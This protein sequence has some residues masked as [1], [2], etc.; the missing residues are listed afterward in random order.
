M[1]HRTHQKMRKGEIQLDS[2]VRHSID[3]VLGVQECWVN[4]QGHVVEINQ[5]EFGR[6]ISFE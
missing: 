6:G 5:P 3:I 4:T 1:D 2:W